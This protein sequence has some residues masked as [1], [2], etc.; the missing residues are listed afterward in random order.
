MKNR[1]ERLSEIL[2]SL[3]KGNFLSTPLLAK[4]FN[5]SKKII[6]SDFKEYLLPLFD[7]NTVYYNYSSKCYKAKDNFLIKSFIGVG[8]LVI[9]SILK[10]KS[11]D[12]YSDKELAK[13]VDILFENYDDA[14]SHSIYTLTDIE[15]IDK[16]K[17]EII[18]IHHAI[19]NK[20]I[21]ECIY[22]NKQRTLYP[23]QIK[24]LDAYWYLICF[25]T[26][27]KDIRKYHLNSIT[28]I[29]ELDEVYDFDIKIIEKFDTAINAWYKPEQEPVCIQLFLEKEVAIYF[30][31]KPI[32]KTQ[33]VI[34]TYEDESCDIELTVTD[35][36][37]IIPTIQ[38]FIPYIIVLAPQSLKDKLVHNTKLYL[39]KNK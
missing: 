19:K 24:N 36:M 32:S 22:K 37:E 35:F 7:D 6:Q 27:Y 10:N 30:Q 15:K 39:E 13:K 25:D 29:I 28:N 21:I 9:I 11:K 26:K 12:K 31:R 33:R 3:S 5:T 20:N 18:Q 2:T 23:L 16:F 1:I 17:N 38:R 34:K 14:L 4:Q 8:E